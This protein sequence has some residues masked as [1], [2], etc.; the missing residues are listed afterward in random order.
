[1]KKNI[2]FFADQANIFYWLDNTNFI[3]SKD[4]ADR[5]GLTGNWDDIKNYK[6]RGRKQG[7]DLVKIYS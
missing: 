3:I 2:I 5:I 1:M 4:V 7:I 6:I